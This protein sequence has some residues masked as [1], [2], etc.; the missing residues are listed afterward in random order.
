MGIYRYK[1]FAPDT[2][3]H[4]YNRGNQKNL[5]FREEDDYFF[6][7][8]RLVQSIKKFNFSLISYC[9]MPNHIHLIVK[10]NG[11]FP[12]A[13]L[14]SSLHTSY[15]MVYNKKYTTV[16][17]LFQDRFKQRIISDDDYMKC[18]ICYIHLNPV[19]DKICHTSEM[20]QWSSYKEYAGLTN[21]H[22]CDHN[23]LEAYNLKGQSFKE[24]INL[25][26][27]IEPYEAFDI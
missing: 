24:F 7:L 5:I 27:H 8:R 12:P 23:L 9:L 6:Y 11:N 21:Y 1:Q 14:I 10:Q 13:K 3:Y 15:A 17:H 25:A 26:K 2:Y 22:R 4:I 20:Y 19:K 18:L 16:G